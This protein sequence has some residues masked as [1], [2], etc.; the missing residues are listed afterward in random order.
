MQL[1]Q[2]RRKTPQQNPFTHHQ[3]SV[4][5]SDDVN[6]QVKIGLHQFDN[7]LSQVKINVKQ[8]ATAILKISG[9]FFIFQQDSAQAH[10][11]C[12]AISLILACNLAKC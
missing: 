9:D 8:S 7:Y 10:R 12:E 6:W 2:Q 4:T 1:S 11:V 5:V 3:H